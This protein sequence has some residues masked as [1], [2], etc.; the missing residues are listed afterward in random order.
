MVRELKSR[1]SF[2][3]VAIQPDGLATR[4]VGFYLFFGGGRRAPAKASSRERLH[5]IKRWI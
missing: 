1:R 5:I 4:P 3:V 2:G